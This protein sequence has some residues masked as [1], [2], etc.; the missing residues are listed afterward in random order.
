MFLK[1]S[2]SFASSIITSMFKQKL[3]W[4]G[5]LVLF[6]AIF[7]WMLNAMYPNIGHDYFYFMP[8]LLVGRM[9]F[10]EQGISPFMYTPYFCGG[11]PQ[12]GNPQGMYYSLQQLFTLMMDPWISVQIAIFVYLII[13]YIGWF[14][15]ARDVMQLPKPWAHLLSVVVSANG[16]YILHM[17]VGHIASLS[18]PICGFLL[19]ILMERKKDTKM[20]LL[21]KSSLFGI[22][23]A[24]AIYSGGYLVVLY[25]GMGFLFALPFEF[26]LCSCSFRDR[27]KVLI[28]RIAACGSVALLLC[29]SKL[30]A[31]LSFM[32]FFPR[33]LAFKSFPKDESIILFILR[34]MFEIPQKKTVFNLKEIGIHDYSVFIS[35]IIV[36]GLLWIVYKLIQSAK[37]R[38]VNLNSFVL[39]SY[40]LVLVLFFV[41]LINGQGI[42]VDWL[43]PLPIFKSLHVMTRFFYV[44]SVMISVAGV[45]GI[46]RLS[47]RFS[48]IAE[49]PS[50]LRFAAAGL[51]RNA[52]V[53]SI[54]SLI[55]FFIAYYPMLTD[56][57]DPLWRKVDIERVRSLADE[58][59]GEIAKAVVEVESLK[60]VS[61][62]MSVYDGFTNTECTEPM[63]GTLFAG[64]FKDTYMGDDSGWG[65]QPIQELTE[66]VPGF[67]TEIS[68]GR[69]NLH[70]PACFIY[71]EENDCE[72]GDRISIYDNENFFR[73]IESK[74]VTW[75]TSLI[76]RVSNWI[77]LVSLISCVLVLVGYR[78]KMKLLVVSG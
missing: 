16:Y 40:V 9:H 70:N 2:A 66:L 75:K 42:L 37:N 24:L 5:P 51:P 76:Q 10:A 61:A 62:F 71:P 56:K 58:S 68:D 19:W 55:A 48:R 8:R 38:S 3:L 72:V 44:S 39:T 7:F 23:S 30:T 50:S 65:K 14:L 53:L 27:L 12:Y 67:V 73:F 31:V 26:T 22:L 59:D 17:V 52:F 47:N 29:A 1:E 21:M 33:G 4:L 13:G 20:S 34:S 49:H 15:F 25:A 43:Q 64:E 18:L 57:S 78:K 35:P 11:M 74:S 45:W 36:I 54:I 32:R 60:G 6:L 46:F 41:Q 28:P 63:L 69:F 77:S